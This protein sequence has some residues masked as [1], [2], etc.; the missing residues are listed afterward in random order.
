MSVSSR[1]VVEGAGDWFDLGADAPT[2]KVKEGLR[3]S[4]QEFSFHQN[5][6]VSW[7][8]VIRFQRSNTEC[9]ELQPALQEVSRKQT[10]R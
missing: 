1:A 6:P 8:S 9:G 4:I 7:I 5:S 10:G 2:V 3:P